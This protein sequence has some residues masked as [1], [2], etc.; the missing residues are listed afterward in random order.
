M[1][2]CVKKLVTIAWADDI[3]DTSILWVYQQPGLT[4]LAGV[5]HEAL[6]GMD[7]LVKLRRFYWFVSPI[8]KL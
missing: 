8:I 7:I 3:F 6:S 2:D 5:V 4:L 1:N